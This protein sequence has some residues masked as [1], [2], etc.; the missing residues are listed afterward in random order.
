MV[1]RF[2]RQRRLFGKLEINQQFFPEPRAPIRLFMQAGRD[3]SAGQ[4]K[5]VRFI[6]D[7]RMA[8]KSSIKI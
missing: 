7:A 8:R 3:P 4:G 1:D 5:S 2:C 6:S